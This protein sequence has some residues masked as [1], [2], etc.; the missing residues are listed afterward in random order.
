MLAGSLAG[1]SLFAHWNVVRQSS[2]PLEIF[3]G[4]SEREGLRST[5]RA[6]NMG[7]KN[8]WRREEIGLN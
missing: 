5:Y 8:G 2:L 6:T 1:F 4:V 3:H 7:E